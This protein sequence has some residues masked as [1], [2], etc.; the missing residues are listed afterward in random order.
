MLSQNR[1]KAAASAFF[2]KSLNCNGLT[3]TIT[4]DKSGANKGGIDAINLQLA[5]LFLFGGI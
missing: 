4:I 3:H 2:S 1:D 5:M